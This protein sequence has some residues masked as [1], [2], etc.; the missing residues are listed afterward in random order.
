VNVVLREEPTPATTA[1]IAI[2][3]PAAI[4]PYS[5]A[6]AAVSLRQKA[7]NFDMKTPSQRSQ[8]TRRRFVSVGVALYALLFTLSHEHNFVWKLQFYREN[9]CDAWIDAKSIS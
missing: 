4:S 9:A 6:V 3:I 1:M 2:D 7:R 5:M 8:M